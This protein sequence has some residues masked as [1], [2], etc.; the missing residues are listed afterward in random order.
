MLEEFGD[1]ASDIR[2]HDEFIAAARSGT[3][4]AVDDSRVTITNENGGQV[5]IRVKTSAQ[6]EVIVS[7]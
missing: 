7:V 1:E 5:H 6:N 4:F 3:I 2:K